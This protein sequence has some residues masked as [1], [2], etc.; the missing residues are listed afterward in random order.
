MHLTGYNG[1]IE[2]ESSS[3]EA[4]D[5]AAKT[6]F[7][8]QM[9]DIGKDTVK[10]VDQAVSSVRFEFIKEDTHS[11]ASFFVISLMVAL[12]KSSAVVKEPEHCKK[13]IVNVMTKME[14][15]GARNL[16]YKVK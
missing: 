1:Y 11:S 16:L 14:N 10:S 3:E 7:D 13:L 5:E 6:F 12:K 4:T 9:K 2:N 15:N 8:E